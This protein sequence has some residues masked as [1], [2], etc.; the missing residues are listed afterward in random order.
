MGIMPELMPK[1]PVQDEWGT[2]TREGYEDRP[3]YQP[4]KA[5][6][7]KAGSSILKTVGSVLVVGGILWATYLGTSLGGFSALLKPGLPS[8]PILVLA[9]GLLLLLLEK[10]IR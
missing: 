1:R 3:V 10:L 9:G 6:P 7:Q 5:A 8:R 4:R 2:S